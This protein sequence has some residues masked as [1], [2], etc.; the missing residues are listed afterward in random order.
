MFQVLPRLLWMLISCVL[1][2][3]NEEFVVNSWELLN[4]A[5]KLCDYKLKCV[6]ECV[7][8]NASAWSGDEWQHR[9]IDPNVSALKADCRF[10]FIAQVTK[11][12]VELNALVVMRAPQGR[13]GT[14]LSSRVIVFSRSVEIIVRISLVSLTVTQQCQLLLELASV[15]ISLPAETGAP[16]ICQHILN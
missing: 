4:G 3:K 8:D 12:T 11:L 5:R 1:L 7:Y 15:T 9:A 10:L 16:S 2:W 14:K 13:C 6:C